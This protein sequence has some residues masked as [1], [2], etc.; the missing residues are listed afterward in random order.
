MIAIQKE[1]KIPNMKQVQDQINNLIQYPTLTLITT[2]GRKLDSISRQ[3]ALRMAQSEGLD[4]VLIT[5]NPPLAKILDYNKHKFELSKKEK[6]IKRKQR[7]NSITLKEIQL[8]PVTSDNDLKRLIEKCQEFL[9]D[10]NK[11][12]VIVKFKNRENTHRELGYEKIKRFLSVLTNFELE[13]D[14]I[15]QTENNINI[16]VKHK[17][18]KA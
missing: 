7:E 13:N 8:R 17:L 1:K 3:E 5:N 10:G 16:I 6:D 18:Q 9:N 11:V 14:R 15:N 2:E 4:L 12:K